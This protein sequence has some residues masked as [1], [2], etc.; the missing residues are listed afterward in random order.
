MPTLDLSGVS[1]IQ[2]GLGTD[3]FFAHSGALLEGLRH[4]LLSQAQDP[5]HPLAHLP[6]G[7]EVA[8]AV[9]HQARL[10][11]KEASLLVVAGIGGSSLGAKVLCSRPGTTVRFLEGVDPECLARRLSEVPWDRAALAVVSKS[12]GTLETLVNAGL[13]LEALKRAVPDRWRHRVVA[14]ASPG[15]GRLQRWAA[16]E[17]VPVLPVP[18]AVGGRYSVLTPVGLLPAAFDGIDPAALLAGARAGADK[19]MLLQGRENPALALATVLFGLYSSGRRE[20]D[21]LGYGERCALFASWIQQLWGESLG[22]RIGEGASAMRVGPTPLA[23]RG[24]EDQ[25]SL[26]QLFVDGPPTRWVL[27]LSASPPGPALPAAVRRFAGLPDRTLNAG[28]VQAALRSGTER[29]LREAGVPVVRYDLE[30]LD[31]VSLGEAFFVFQAATMVAAALF[32]VDP[33]GQ[34]GVEA[35]KRFTRSI[36]EGEPWTTGSGS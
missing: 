10:L 33:F 34:P 26:L 28:M 36:L 6:P 4:A 8:A 20:V 27:L 9:R 32:E 18:A 2:P 19:S 7:D 24:S 5:A 21:L 23:C 3:A 25:H 15:E 22:R 35:G 14:V 29:A 30:G 1:Q 11:R 16:S 31:A 17:G 12:G 13:C